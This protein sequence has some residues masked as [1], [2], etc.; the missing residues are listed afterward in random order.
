M[1]QTQ[2][3]K[4][5]NYVMEWE[6]F[7]IGLQGYFLSRTPNHDT[8]EQMQNG[9]RELSCTMRKCALGKQIQQNTL[10]QPGKEP[11]AWHRCF[12]YKQKFLIQAI[13]ITLVSFQKQEMLSLSGDIIIII[14]GRA[15]CS[16]LMAY[17]CFEI[18][19]QPKF[20]INCVLQMY[21]V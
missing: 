2:N 12:Q 8:S 17:R 15:K 11:P 13:H 18:L 9:G 10:T 19:P 20:P 3:V 16:Q 7:C 6:E 1:H 14:L 5:S 21:T 4:L